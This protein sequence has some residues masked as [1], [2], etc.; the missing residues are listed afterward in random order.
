MTSKRCQ[1]ST[2]DIEEVSRHGSN[3]QP[4][5]AWFPSFP[6]FTVYRSILS[7]LFPGPPG[8]GNVGMFRPMKRPCG[9]S[10]WWPIVSDGGLKFAPPLDSYCS[11]K[12]R[13]YFEAAA[14]LLS[15]ATCP[16]PP[17]A[18]SLLG[19]PPSSFFRSG[20]RTRF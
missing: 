6:S 17:I 9:L 11:T 3:L 15:N 12:L 13:S 7:H 1:V 5:T 20:S 4:L 18:G 14:S 8:F 16:P 10:P 2:H 19:L